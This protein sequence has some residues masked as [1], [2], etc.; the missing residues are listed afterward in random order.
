MEEPRIKKRKLKYSGEKSTKE[1]LRL[2]ERLDRMPGMIKI[3]FDLSKQMI[4]LQYDL[5]QVQLDSVEKKMMELE[6]QLSPGRFQRFKRS[7]IK[8][9]ET[10]E[11]DNLMT[12]PRPCCHIPRHYYAEKKGDRNS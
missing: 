1:L 4:L 11:K 3:E 9:T 2:Q 7:W 12:I 8:Y 6:F 5:K 10:N